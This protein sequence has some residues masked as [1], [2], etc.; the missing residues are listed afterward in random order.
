MVP[1]SGFI[2][3]ILDGYRAGNYTNLT[4]SD[5]LGAYTA[6]LLSDRRNLIIVSEPDRSMSMS[7]CGYGERQWNGSSVAALA[8]ELDPGIEW[9]A[10]S[11]NLSGNDANIEYFRQQMQTNGTWFV[12]SY[13]NYSA[14]SKPPS[15]YPVQYCLSETRGVSYCQLQFVSDILFVV[16]VCNL[17][18][19]ICMSF[20]AFHLWDLDEPILATVGDCVASFLERPDETTA[21]W[22]LLDPTNLDGWCVRGQQFPRNLVYQRPSK[23]RLYHATTTSRWWLRLFLCSYYLVVG[24][25]LFGLSLRPNST[26]NVAE[27]MKAKFGAVNGNLL[28]GLDGTTGQG[29]ILDVLVA[30]L[31]QLALSTTYFLYN[32][33]YTAQCGALEWASFVRGERKALRV[34]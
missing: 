18:K 5:C 10:S 31:F 13:V 3:R 30:N 4:A 15:L 28:L 33:L 29:L 23:T 34:T 20:V 26:D 7:S 24:F 21:G 2:P 22:C 12:G 27:I 16:V 14:S 32:S 1:V 11:V 19:V 17:V 6:D 8:F 9:I 25:L